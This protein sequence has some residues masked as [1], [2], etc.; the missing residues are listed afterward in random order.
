[1]TPI[2]PSDIPAPAL[3]RRYRGAGDYAD[4]Y[5]TELPGVVTHAAFVEAFYTT[6]LFRVERALL[7][8]L[9]GFPS[10]DAQARQLAAGERDTF[11][12]WHVEDRA[13]NQLLVRAGRTRSWFMTSI[14]PTDAAAGS[15]TLLYFGS[16]VVPRRGADG[17]RRLG[18]GFHAL[19]GFHKLY[20]RA[21]LRAAG[22]RLMNGRR[23]RTP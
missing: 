4:C 8:W 13:E 6:R 7:K 2:R 20:S 23:D 21:L 9:A 5:V 3:L 1:V 19:L 14:A 17:R 12:A 16:A 11:A 18:A 22:S 15:R 10:T